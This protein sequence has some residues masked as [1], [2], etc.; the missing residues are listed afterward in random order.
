MEGYSNEN[1]YPEEKVT[2]QEALKMFTIWPAY[3]SFEEN[4]L[5]TIEVGK[6]ADFSAFKTDLMTAPGPEILTSEP[7]FTMVNGKMAFDGRSE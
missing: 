6:R 5:G 4:K 3:A 2:R 7:L 1:W